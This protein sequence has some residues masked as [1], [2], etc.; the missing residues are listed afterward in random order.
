MTEQE[1]DPF[2]IPAM[3]N[4]GGKR[5]QQ[6]GIQLLSISGFFRP[7]DKDK[8][9]RVDKNGN[10]SIGVRLI[11]DAGEEIEA[12]FYYSKH[13]Y[14]TQEYKDNPCKSEWRFV[15]FKKSLKIDPTIPYKGSDLIGI[16]VWVGIKKTAYVDE[17]TG[18]ILKNGKY[19]KVFYSVETFFPYTEG[20]EPVGIEE[21]KEESSKSKYYKIIPVPHVE[22]DPEASADNGEE[23][24]ANPDDDF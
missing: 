13:K 8:K 5:I 6:Q 11:N 3:D 7:V 24:A 16:K 21:S 1:Q 10:P 19:D 15:N 22:E 2:E 20:K 12:E 4:S 14:G 18:E 23:S 17:Q 9:P